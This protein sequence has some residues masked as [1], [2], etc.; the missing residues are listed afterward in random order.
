MNVKVYD[1]NNNLIDIYPTIASAAK[2]YNVDHNTV[3]KCIKNG[4]LIN[5]RR[6]VSEIKDVRVWILD[7]NYYTVNLF[8]TAQKS[9]SFVIHLI[10]H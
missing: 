10:Q 4:N 2:H 1:D 3:S 5:N 9:L 6:F 8:S 7:K